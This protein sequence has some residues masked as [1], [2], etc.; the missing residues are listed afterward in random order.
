MS[1]PVW[2]ELARILAE[3]KDPFDRS[4]LL[5]IVHLRDQYQR[6]RIRGENIVRSTGREDLEALNVFHERQEHEVEKLYKALAKRDPACQW[7]TSVFGVGAVLAL[8]I[9]A[10]VDISICETAGRIWR[11]AGMTTD[12]PKPKKG[13]K[14][15]FCRP[16]K[17][18]VFLLAESFKRL[19]H[20]PKSFYGFA[21]R[22][23][24]EIEIARNEQGRFAEQAE[25]ILGEKNFAK[26]TV[27]KKAYSE[28]KLPPGHLDMR[29]MR[30]VGKLFLSHWHHVAYRAHFGKE[31]PK[32]YVIAIMGHQDL[33]TPE[34]VLAWEAERR[35][36]A[37]Q[38]A[39]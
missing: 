30:W 27:A 9:R 3:S 23:R 11:F 22:T 34:S 39:G 31:P 19:S 38:E 24:K 17:R 12:T 28:G 8:T 14:L 25:K 37:R 6:M 2:K 10:H 29:A 18:T 20:N 7:A 32:P 13:E 4:T 36:N 15:A 1:D 21:Y 5:F 16:L 33:V 26:S 35:E